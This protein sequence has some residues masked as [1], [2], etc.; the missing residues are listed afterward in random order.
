MPWRLRQ[1]VVPTASCRETLAG[2]LH[3]NPHVPPPVGAFPNET[4]RT[5]QKTLGVVQTGRWDCGMGQ[6]VSARDKAGL[7]LVACA[8]G[9]CSRCGCR[10]AT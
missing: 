4:L 2:E 8:S 5:L 9:G 10:A 3:V 7:D 6:I 1:E